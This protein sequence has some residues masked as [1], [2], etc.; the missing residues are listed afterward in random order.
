M[1][2]QT[3]LVS[4]IAI[5]LGLAL[6]LGGY[7]FFMILLPLWAF[8]AGFSS[9]A[10]A[11]TGFW[12][13]AFL[14]TAV[15]WVVGILVG[16]L[17]AALAYLFYYAAIIILGGIVG[18]QLGVGFMTWIGF[19]LGFITMLVALALAIIFAFGAWYLK[20]PKLVIIILTS[21]AG[22]AS[23]LAGIFLAFGTIPLADLQW[24]AVG[25]VVRQSWWWTL[26][27]L[28]LALLGV[29]A[30]WLLTSSRYTLD[31]YSRNVALA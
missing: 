7:R 22:A 20:V 14:T 13:T 1:F 2:L 27:Y 12:G 6:S 18:Y 21:L 29:A 24:G 10:T 19:K 23:L 16:L 15:S 28:A 3:I 30:Q 4:L 31:A 9:T 25:A 11:I 17:F 5:L 26:V 8:F